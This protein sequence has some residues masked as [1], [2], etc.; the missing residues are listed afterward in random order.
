MA[1]KMTTALQ[2]TWSS[3]HSVPQGSTSSQEAT[4]AKR[5]I[6]M[7]KFGKGRGSAAAEAGYAW[8]VGI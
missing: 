6:D 1:I 7:K 8:Y 2:Q 5:S 4:T 3:N